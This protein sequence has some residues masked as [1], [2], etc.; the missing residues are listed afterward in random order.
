[1]K[2][3][4][5]FICAAGATLSLLDLNP[6]STENVIVIN[7]A[8]T[9][10]PW[11]HDKDINWSNNKFWITTDSTVLCWSYF[12]NQVLT[13]NLTKIIRYSPQWTQLNNIFDLSDFSFFDGKLKLETENTEN[14]LL[15]Y[16]SAVCAI[17]FAFLLGCKEIYIL[18]LDHTKLVG[19]THCWEL[20]DTIHHPI[21]YKYNRSRVEDFSNQESRFISNIKYF[22]FLEKKA[23]KNNINIFNCSDI[24]M[25]NSFEKRDYP[26]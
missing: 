5:C 13:S 8:I 20:L 17:D 15:S 2:G 12:W 4:R 1:M 24:S 19:K 11:L 9:L 22:N 6:L 7:S 14:E 10:L 26:F 25:V 21:N 23:K 16:T 3:E 18:G